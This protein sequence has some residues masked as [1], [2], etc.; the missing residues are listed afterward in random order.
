MREDCDLLKVNKKQSP[1]SN[2]R[3]FHSTGG[4]CLVNVLMIVLKKSGESK[5]LKILLGIVG[6]AHSISLSWSQVVLEFLSEFSEVSGKISKPQGTWS[7]PSLSTTISVWLWITSIELDESLYTISHRQ[8]EL[9]HQVSK[10]WSPLYAIE[11]EKFLKAL[12]SLW[13]LIRGTGNNMQGIFSQWK[14]NRTL[15]LMGSRKETIVLGPFT[16]SRSVSIFS[17]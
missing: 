10:W 7:I 14:S 9:I 3:S 5:L 15:R 13:N 1:N 4:R 12:L 11:M 6:D 17:G 2:R 8:W 16:R